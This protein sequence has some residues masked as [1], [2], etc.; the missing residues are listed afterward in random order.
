MNFLDAPLRQ[1][2][3]GIFLALLMVMGTLT[4]ALYLLMWV[5]YAGIYDTLAG[6]AFA[7]TLRAGLVVLA[8]NEVLMYLLRKL[9]ALLRRFGLVRV[10]F[11][12]KVLNNAAFIR[13][14][15]RKL[16]RLVF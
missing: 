4:V 2:F 7:F 16:S 15:V 10:L 11:S 3:T 6:G 12:P 1:T 14:V 9:N 13:W 8:L 5:Q